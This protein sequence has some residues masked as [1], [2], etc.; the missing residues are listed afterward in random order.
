MARK[1]MQSYVPEITTLKKPKETFKKELEERISIGNEFWERKVN[2]ITQ[3]EKLKDDYSRWDDYNEELLKRSFNNIRNEYYESY[4]SC[5]QMIGVEDVL[6]R[7]N[8][9]S[10]EYQLQHEKEKIKASITNLGK[11][12]EKLPLIDVADGILPYSVKD[13][14]FTNQCFL[15][16]GHNE[17]KKFEIARFIE[18]DLRIRTVILHE[19][20]NKGRTIIE[21]FVDYSKVD[22]AVALWTADD[23]GKAKS[24]TD[25]KMRTRQNVIFE[26]GFFIG[27]LGRENVI[28]L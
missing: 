14:T 7:V 18:N 13:R 21:K 8:T 24:E 16:H 1:K 20:P 26:T 19:Q 9:R 3:L 28:V 22:F 4:E 23:E 5:T 27:K 12:V 15:V 11:L 25:L 10:G 6:M 17:S 2:D